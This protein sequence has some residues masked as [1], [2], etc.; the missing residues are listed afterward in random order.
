MVEENS[1]KKD[2]VSLRSDVKYRRFDLYRELYP[3]YSAMAILGGWFAVC[4]GIV[5]LGLRSK[6]AGK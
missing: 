1:K 6:Q 5:F 2:M 4:Y 3:A